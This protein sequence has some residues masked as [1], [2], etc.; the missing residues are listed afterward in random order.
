[1]NDDMKLWNEIER[2]TGKMVDL[3]H[4]LTRAEDEVQRLRNGSVR[5][6]VILMWINGLILLAGAGGIAI[7]AERWVVVAA[8]IL[9]ALTPLA[10]AYDVTRRHWRK[11]SWR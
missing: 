9:V 6:G 2:L 1:M 3:D 8:L 5:W 7:G 4:Q 10:G 11:L